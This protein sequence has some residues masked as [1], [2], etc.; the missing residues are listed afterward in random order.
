MAAFDNKNDYLKSLNMKADICSINNLMFNEVHEFMN[1]RNTF[2]LTTKKISTSILNN[3][4]IINLY[5]KFHDKVE[6]FGIVSVISCYQKG[7]G[8]HI[9]SWFMNANMI[10]FEMGFAIFDEIIIKSKN[11][12]LKKIFAEYT[13][14]ENNKLCLDFLNNLGFKLLDDDENGDKYFILDIPSYEYKNKFIEV[15]KHD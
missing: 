1:N 8:L 5:G 15:I 14:Q 7:M 9:N 13:P 12:G 6:N 3:P 2:N 11:L 10:N 4:N